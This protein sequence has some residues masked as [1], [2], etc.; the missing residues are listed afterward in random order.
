MFMMCLF[1]VGALCEADLK[2]TV[3]KVFNKYMELM[4]LIQELYVL[5]PANPHG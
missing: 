1:K 2:G 3:N 4:R 5:E